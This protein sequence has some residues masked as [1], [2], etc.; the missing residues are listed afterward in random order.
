MLLVLVFI[1]DLRHGDVF[2]ISMLLVMRKLCSPFFR[3][4]E[5]KDIIM[6]ITKI[7]VLVGTLHVCNIR[8]SKSEEEI[9]RQVYIVV[10][11][12]VYLSGCLSISACLFIGY[13]SN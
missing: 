6:I 13:L 5:T 3:V 11:L 12:S 4:S 10:C 7:F 2:V 9:E 1:Y 8:A